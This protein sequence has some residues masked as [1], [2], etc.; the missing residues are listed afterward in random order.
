MAFG[1]FKS[2]SKLTILEWITKRAWQWIIYYLKQPISTKIHPFQKTRI[3]LKL[4]N[5]QIQNDVC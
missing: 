1:Y 5:K 2:G 4:Q 3:K